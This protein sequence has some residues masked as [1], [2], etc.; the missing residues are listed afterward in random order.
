[1]I[2]T[3]DEYP[4][5]RLAAVCTFTCVTQNLLKSFQ[6]ARR[7]LSTAP[8]HCRPPTTCSCM[9]LFARVHRLFQH[10]VARCSTVTLLSI[11]HICTSIECRHLRKA[12]RV[13]AI[14]APSPQ[15]TGVQL[16]QAEAGSCLRIPPAC[17]RVQEPPAC[18]NHNYFSSRSASSKSISD[19]PTA[20]M[21]I[22]RSSAKSAARSEFKAPLAPNSGSQK[23]P[24]LKRS[25]SSDGENSELRYCS[26]RVDRL[27]PALASDDTACIPM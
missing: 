20:L 9:H 24:I 11:L 16:V 4:R 6:R 25:S 1:M 22:L 14:Q 12:A 2:L 17:V 7:A 8:V 26:L 19:I 15:E 21:G 27:P 3:S 5:S 18:T 10:S 23:S 13:P